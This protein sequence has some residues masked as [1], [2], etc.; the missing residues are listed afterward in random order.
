MTPRPKKYWGQHFLAD[1]HLARQI[2][3]TIEAPPPVLVVEIGPGKGILT[4]YLLEKP[5]QY[6]GVEI[7]PELAALLRT[8][9]AHRPNFRLLEEDFLTLNLDALFQAYPGHTPVV[10]GNIPYNITGPILFKLFEYHSRLF[11]ATLMVQKEVARRII[12]APGSKD[13]GIVSI[14][15]QLYARTEYLWTVP[16]GRFFPRPQVDSAVVRFRFRNNATRQIHNPALFQ[17]LVQTAFRQRRKMLKNSLS[18]LFPKEVFNKLDFDF[19]LR[20]EQV[21][22]RDWIHLANQLNRLYSM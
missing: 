21:P 1:Q 11:Q 7:D 19:H 13:Y 12:A 22:I 17:R 5:V 4:R 8:A 14:F 3:D 20:P 9:W 10:V 6:V 15:S 18:V 16:A 2:A